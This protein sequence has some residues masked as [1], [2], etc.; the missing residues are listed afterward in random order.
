[1]ERRGLQLVSEDGQQ[2]ES[3]TVGD[4]NWSRTTVEPNETSPGKCIS[5]D[6]RLK[7][8]DAIPDWLKPTDVFRKKKFGDEIVENEL[9]WINVNA[10]NY[11]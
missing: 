9:N 11:N 8:F 6:T 4:G 10:G 2:R 3:A 1:M 7:R 5:D